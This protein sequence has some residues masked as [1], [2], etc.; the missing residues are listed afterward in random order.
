[1]LT[2]INPLGERARKQNF[3]VTVL[4]YLIG[5]VLGG[6]AI[7]LVGGTVGSI[8]PAGSWRLAAV[9]GVTI[10]GAWLDYTEYVPFSIHRQVD[11]NWLTRYRGWVYGL[12]FG[13][14]L[15]LAIVTII[16]SAS[17][18]TTI[19]L[20]VLVGSVKW[21]IVIGIAFGVARGLVIFKTTQVHDHSSLRGLMRSLQGGLPNAKRLT[22][23][24]QLTMTVAAVAAMI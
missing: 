24:A 12:G 8:L 18:Y 21:G 19:A 5:S 2:S 3:T 1:M 4:F 23:G 16:T 11:E 10:A 22:V 14:Q 13:F 9:V 17:V 15:G 20:A 7:G 6:A